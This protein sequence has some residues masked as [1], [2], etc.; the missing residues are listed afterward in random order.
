M[1]GETSP[2]AKELLG[3]LRPFTYRVY[4]DYSAFASLRSMK[5]MINAEV[6]RR[7]LED[8]VKLGSGGIRE[9]EFIVQAFQLIRG[10]QDRLLQTRELCHVLDILAAEGYLPIE[11]CEQLRSAYLFLRDSEHAIQALADEQTQ[12]LPQNELDQARIAWGMNCDD[13]PTYLQQLSTHR[14]NV[15]HHFAQIVANDENNGQ[16]SSALNHAWLDLWHGELTGAAADTFLAEHPCDNAKEVQDKLSTFRE[17]RAVLNMQQV[18]RERLE[19]LMPLL[20]QKLW[21]QTAPLTTL[22]RLI[23]LLEAVLRRTAYLVLLKENPQALKQLVRLCNASSWVAE[24]IT[25]TPLLLDELL[26]VT[27]LYRLP[28]AA[29]LREEL[30]L[31]L[32]RI[33]PDD[34]EQQ[35]EQLR[36]F[37][38]AHKLRAAACEVMEA[39][40]LMQVSDYLTWLA[41]VTLTTVMN[42]AWQ[43]MVDK[44]GYPTDANNDAVAEPEFLILGYGK[45][46]GLEI[47]YSSDLDLVFIHNGIAGKATNG[48]RSLDNG[49]FYT[50]MGQRMVHI[51]TAQTRSGD[52]YEVDLRLRPSGNSGMIVTSLK[53]F[54]E[55][56]E[57]HAWTWEHQAL[58]RARVLCGQAA[59]ATA[60]KAVR[61]GILSRPRNIPALRE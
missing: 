49:V 56:Q 38:R 33:D 12:Q 50:R 31:R 37:V 43:Q 41:E 21:L 4:V 35:M 13:W 28:S 24:Y 10:G 30:H 32:L 36:Q 61:E 59:L 53:A 7:G 60:T 44:Y 23:P 11:A 46:G 14:Q 5:D 17:S 18:G 48:E 42:L 29:E 19:E 55:Y 3:I 9:V 40:T 15:S 27:S 52:L 45:V 20:L 57:K 6:R 26:D 51:L 16:D 22:E 1:N 34:L 39:L 8:N 58:V 25:Q 2:A 47:S 54:S